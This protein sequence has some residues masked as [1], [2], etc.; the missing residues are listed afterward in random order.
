MY[1]V[2][3][4][5]KLLAISLLI[6][7]VGC[8]GGGGGSSS[9]SFTSNTTTVTTPTTVTTSTLTFPL[10]T[11]FDTY[12]RTNKFLSAT[13]SGTRNSKAVTGNLTD[14]ILFTTGETASLI[15]STNFVANTCCFTSFT[16]LNKI[17]TIEAVS[18][19]TDGTTIA[20]SITS[21]FYLT[22]TNTPFVQ[23]DTTNKIQA[24][25]A[26]YSSFPSAVKVGDTGSF[27]TASV[28]DYSA[29]DGSILLCGSQTVTYSI[30]ADTST[31]VLLKISYN[32]SKT[33]S[34]CVNSL[35]NTLVRVD[36][37]RLSQT[38]LSLISSTVTTASS[39]LTIAY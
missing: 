19:T 1:P 4:I 18:I 17:R 9:S 2:A 34:A 22:S 37:Y 35:T 6:F 13:I 11:L 14:N 38:S 32:Q 3:I 36:S 10:A 24:T 33:N 27:Y 29:V 8:G 26:N 25:I 12:L 16:N 20:T 21:D 31:S 23:N 30:E 15:N 28:Y 5:A 39:A 7:L